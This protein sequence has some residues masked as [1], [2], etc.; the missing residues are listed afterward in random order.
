MI[1]YSYITK[2]FICIKND[3]IYFDVDTLE[4]TGNSK[5][6]SFSDINNN[7]KGLYSITHNKHVPSTT[8]HERIFFISTINYFI[9]ITVNSDKYNDDRNNIN[10]K[11]KCDCEQKYSGALIKQSE[12]FN[13][14]LQIDYINDI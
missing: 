1:N 11:M 2:L 3:I 12:D 5:Y 6:I 9:T 13:E 4:Y 10:I 7:E 14:I 8:N